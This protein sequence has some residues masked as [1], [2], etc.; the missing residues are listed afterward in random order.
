MRREEPTQEWRSGWH[1]LRA[2]GDV[3]CS[4]RE[5]NGTGA[6]NEGSTYADVCFAVGYGLG[7]AVGS[8]LAAR[9]KDLRV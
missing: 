7:G 5:E 4:G 6:G 1:R 8:G 2:W 9:L 3:A